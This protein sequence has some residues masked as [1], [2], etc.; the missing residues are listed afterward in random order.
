MNPRTLCACQLV[1][2]IISFKVA[3][4]GRLSRSITLAVLLP[5]RAPVA[6]PL[7][8]DA[9]LATFLGLFVL[10]AF[11]PELAAFLAGAAISVATGG[12]CSLLCVSI[13]FV[14]IGLSP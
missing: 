11:L 13:V 1:T 14:F 3:P 6:L 12:V 8:F 5:S 2:F 7:A 10:P 9:G 4:P